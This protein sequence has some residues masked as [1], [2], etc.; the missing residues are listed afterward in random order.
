MPSVK[1]Y[2]AGGA[3]CLRLSRGVGDE[4]VSLANRITIGLHALEF[5]Q[6]RHKRCRLY[7][8][9]T[10]GIRVPVTR[11]GNRSGWL[12][13]LVYLKLTPDS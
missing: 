5:T 12:A 8:L 4:L 2:G 13:G 11:S 10:F 7:T 3:V 9:Y 6:H 1:V